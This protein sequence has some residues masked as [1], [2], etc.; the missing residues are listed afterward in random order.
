MKFGQTDKRL[1]EFDFLGDV[2]ICNSC[3]RTFIQY[4]FSDPKREREM[5]ALYEAH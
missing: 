1:T 4:L 5:L 2:I 3:S